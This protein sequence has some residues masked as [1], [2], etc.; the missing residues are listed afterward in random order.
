MP[1]PSRVAL[2]DVVRTIEIPPAVSAAILAQISV[3]LDRWISAR[4]PVQVI[5][6]RMEDVALERG[7]GVWWRRGRSVP[8]PDAVG[9]LGC[10]LE[11]L[12]A[13]APQRQA[14]PGLVYVVS[15]ATDPGHLAPIGSV[16]EFAAAV[17]RHA[18]ARPLGAIDALI[19]RHLADACGA[20]SL[21]RDSTIADVRRRRRAGGTPLRTIAED[22]HI[23]VSLLRELEWG[24]YDNWTL[25]H[26][27]SSV[28]AYAERAGLDP[29]NV[30]AV[31][32]RDQQQPETLLPVRVGPTSLAARADR[33]ELRHHA[34]PFALAALLVG[35]LAVAAP[36]DHA[37]PTATVNAET[38]VRPAADRKSV[39]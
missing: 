31:I 19:A 38:I 17:T 8:A 20:A 28:A 36:S 7:G 21:G 27:A 39:V 35:V 30:L 37:A 3:R 4:R 32:G 2:T 23:P 10:L 12:L 24:V 9:A 22:T 15:R 5:V 26:A 1:Q 14:P 16:R 34:L 33:V 13:R 25:P 6:P 11:A 18:P 29:G